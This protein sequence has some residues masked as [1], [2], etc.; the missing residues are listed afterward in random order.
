MN[1]GDRK[2]N[3][4]NS[5][6]DAGFL[7]FRY[8]SREPHWARSAQREMLEAV[9]RLAREDHSAVDWNAFDSFIVLV[10]RLRFTADC[11]FHHVCQLQWEHDVLADRLR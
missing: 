1:A 8:L 9:G 10:L 3:G 5:N 11:M 4:W 7:V 6:R 2:L